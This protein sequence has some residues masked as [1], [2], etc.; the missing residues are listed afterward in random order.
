MLPHAAAKASLAKAPTRAQY[1]ALAAKRAA[2]DAVRSK[3]Y[4]AMTNAERNQ[5]SGAEGVDPK[6]GKLFG[7]PYKK[8]G[9]AKC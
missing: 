4:G 6:T 1:D 5:I 3:G 7:R 9:S 2:A 8:G